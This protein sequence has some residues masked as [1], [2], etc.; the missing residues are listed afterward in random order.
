MS[1]D[2]PLWG[3]PRIHG[4]SLTLGFDIA[5]WTLRE[6]SDWGVSRGDW[7]DALARATPDGVHVN[8]ENVG[9]EIVDAVTYDAQGR[10]VLCGL[11][12]SYKGDGKALDDFSPILMR[13]LSVGGFVILDFIKARVP[14]QVVG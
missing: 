5:Q 13:R 1:V 3:A 6:C 10:M 7:R 11:I 4:E 2:D 14:M 8:F 9:G 12:S